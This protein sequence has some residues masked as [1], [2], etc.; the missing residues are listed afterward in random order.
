MGKER[1]VWLDYMKVIG[2]F[3]IVAGHLSPPGNEFVYVFSVPLFFVC[4]G[5]LAKK[6]S[7]IKVCWDKMVNRM[8]VP[9]ILWQIPMIFENSMVVRLHANK[10]WGEIFVSR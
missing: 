1:L 4:S 7:S 9:A 6:E 8:I 2:M 3:L 10:G 5:I